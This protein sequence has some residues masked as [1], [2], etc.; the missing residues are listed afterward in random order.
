MRRREQSEP[1][2]LTREE[3]R[4]LLIDWLVWSARRNT[5]ALRERLVGIEAELLAAGI[6]PWWG[7][8]E[9]AA[10]QDAGQ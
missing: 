8:A 10:W 6:D 9:F 5:P 1:P 2:V 4:E 7:D 3:R